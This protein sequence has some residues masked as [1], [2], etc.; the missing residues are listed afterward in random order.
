MR[1]WILAEPLQ[2]VTS[3]QEPLAPA[4]EA[5]RAQGAARRGLLFFSPFFLPPCPATREAAPL[6]APRP[7]SVSHS[8]SPQIYSHVAP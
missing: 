1:P 2:K 6:P 8:L 5:P 3:G 4:A 7:F